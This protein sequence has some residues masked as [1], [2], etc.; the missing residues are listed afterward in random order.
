MRIMAV[1]VSINVTCDVGYEWLKSDHRNVR[2]TKHHKKDTLSTTLEIID[3][4]FWFSCCY[5]ILHNVHWLWYVAAAGAAAA[6]HTYRTC[7]H[8]DGLMMLCVCVFLG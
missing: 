4:S 6:H 2:E 1:L 7:R 5:C 8:G 3:T